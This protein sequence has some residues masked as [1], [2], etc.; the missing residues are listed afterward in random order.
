[1]VTEYLRDKKT[2]GHI[3]LNEPT[4]KNVSNNPGVA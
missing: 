1:V 2:I 4:L 3:E